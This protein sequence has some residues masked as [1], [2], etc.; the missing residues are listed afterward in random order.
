MDAEEESTMCYGCYEEYGKPEIVSPVTLT[1]L[2][3]VR[4]VY[5]FSSVGG[6]LHCQLDDW[7]IEDEF[8]EEFTVYQVDV[9]SQ[10]L[11]AERACFDAFKQMSLEERASVLAMHDGILAP[12]AIT[13][14]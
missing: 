3:H 10:Q 2:G 6:N 11:A 12:P 1:G 8:F 4:R 13:G 9:T 5:E 14:E 7:N